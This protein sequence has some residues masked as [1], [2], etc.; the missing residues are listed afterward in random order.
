VEHAVQDGGAD[1][2]ERLRSRMP[3][4]SREAL[5]RAARMMIAALDEG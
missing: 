1:S 3:T 2:D 4:R 5:H